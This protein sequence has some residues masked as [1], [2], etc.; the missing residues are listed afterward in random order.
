MKYLSL[1]FRNTGNLV[2]RICDKIARTIYR[3][4]LTKKDESWSAFY[5]AGGEHIRYEYTSL[6]KE[7][8]VF[9]LGGYEGQWASD[10]YSRF[11]P[12]LYIFEVYT[13][14]F[15]NIEERFRFNDDIKVYNFGLSSKDAVEEISIDGFSTSAF[16]KSA[17]MVNIQIKKASD[18]ISATGIKK[19]DLIKINIEGAEYELLDHLIATGIIKTIDHLQIQFHDFIPD[20]VTKMNQLRDKLALTHYP[21]Y[22]FDF[23]WENWKLK[24]STLEK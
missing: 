17:H 1:F 7:S 22:K 9:D 3:P 6:N 13:P 5:K 21:T 16:K 14:Y 12:K 15:D 2:K 23:I 24:E 10:I 4:L 8:V 11:R 20:A 18:F 19:I